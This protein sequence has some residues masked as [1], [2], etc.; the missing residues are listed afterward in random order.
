M[1]PMEEYLERQIRIV[2]HRIGVLILRYAGQNDKAQ[3]EIYGTRFIL[4]VHHNNG[5][6]IVVA[7]NSVK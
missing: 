5:A 4:M 2:H 1:R 7:N 6:E 3:L